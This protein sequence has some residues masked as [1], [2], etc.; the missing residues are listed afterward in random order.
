MSLRSSRRV[1][2]RKR[3]V[4]LRASTSAP[5][6][7]SDFEKAID[8]EDS[9]AAKAGGLDK[10]FEAAWAL[11]Y[12]THGPTAG[13]RGQPCYWCLNSLIFGCIGPLHRGLYPDVVDGAA[14]SNENADPITPD[15]RVHPWNPAKGILCEDCLGASRS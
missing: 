8:Y 3:V 7:T 11:T 12:A 4:Q 14:T 13:E 5:M 1:N 6:S 9:V 2:R 15:G 10:L